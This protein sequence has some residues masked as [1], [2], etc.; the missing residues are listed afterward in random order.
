MRTTRKSMFV[1]VMAAMAFALS[2]CGDDGGAGESEEMGPGEMS[3]EMDST[4]MDDSDMGGS[5]M[6]ESEMGSED[7]GGSD[8]D[9]S[10]MESDMNG[11]DMEAEDMG[12]EDMGGED[13]GAEEMDSESESTV[14]MGAVPGIVPSSVSHAGS[15][16]L[17]DDGFVSGLLTTR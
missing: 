1:G 6:G 2:A 9:G 12:A 17:L 7:M 13:M 3:S 14:G 16:V 4:E 5:D 15:V 11:S 8:M 10:G